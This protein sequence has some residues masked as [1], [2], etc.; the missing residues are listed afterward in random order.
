M[1]MFF[2]FFSWYFV[3][4]IHWFLIGAGIST[5]AGVAKGVEGIAG[6]TAS[7]RNGHLVITEHF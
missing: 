4:L 5:G 3:D 6:C 7:D 2:N 1:F